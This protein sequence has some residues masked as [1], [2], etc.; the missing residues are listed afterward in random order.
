MVKKEPYS[1]VSCNI[2]GGVKNGEKSAG[3]HEKSGKAG[4]AR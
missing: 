2:F 1:L 3:C 4:E